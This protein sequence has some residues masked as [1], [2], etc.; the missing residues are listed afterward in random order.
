[1]MID[2]LAAGMSAVQTI[3]EKF[4]D[5]ILHGHRA[6]HGAQT[7]FPE[8]IIDGKLFEFRHG[9]SMKAWSLIARIAGIDQFHI[10]APKGKMESKNRTVLE[11]LEACTRP[12]G[13]LKT[14]RPIC[15]G[16]LKATVLWDVA[17]IM[18]PIGDYPNH[19][20]ICQA[21]G[22][23]HSHDLG[24][25]GGS[26]S[27]VQARDCITKGITPQQAMGRYFE[28]LLAF[29]K[30]DN[31][32]Y[33]KW[34]KTLTSESKIVVD[35]DLRPYQ[36]NGVEKEPKPES[37]TLDIAIEKYPLLKEDLEKFNPEL[38]KKIS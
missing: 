36:K 8:V 27:M 4:P 13:K 16:G 22:G 23:T 5:M 21:G 10:G 19:D 35:P 34:L 28:T 7:I 9:V 1:L 3:R 37:V 32:I 17:K 2:I 20:I 30:W 31:A 33:G 24:T 14:M 18:N 29:R 6:G 25:I 15:S 26:K 12:L 38:L 11:N